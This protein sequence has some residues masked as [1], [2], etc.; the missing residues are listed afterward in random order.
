MLKFNSGEISRQE[1]L[2]RVRLIK[3]N[4]DFY[5]DNP[6]VQDPKLEEYANVYE[7]LID[8]H[9]ITPEEIEEPSES[10]SIATTDNGTSQAMDPVSVYYNNNP[11]AKDEE[12]FIKANKMDRNYDLALPYKPLYRAST[13]EFDASKIFQ[14]RREEF[15]PEKHKDWDTS[16]MGQLADAY[17]LGI[18]PDHYKKAIKAGVPHDYLMDTFQKSARPHTIQL[19]DARALGT[20]RGVHFADTNAG[21][22]AREYAQ[23]NPGPTSNATG[24]ANEN[25]V[26]IRMSV[27]HPLDIASG[28]TA[29]AT[30]DEL[31]DAWKNNGFHPLAQ[32]GSE[33]TEPISKYISARDMGINHNEAKALISSPTYI[34]EVDFKMD[35]Q[36]GNSPAAIINI[37]NG[38]KPDSI[39]GPGKIAIEN[40]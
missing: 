12:E 24:I 9:G 22:A 5:Y 23:D 32:Y 13:D 14:Q 38:Y 35:L 33:F 34:P 28:Y 40:E 15:D 36:K 10:E 25:W 16:L 3:P 37:R 39:E 30:S 8:Q 7:Q 26:P 4:V 29:G 6:T 21:L 19:P 27:M 1:A 20:V 2:D 11:E 17:E 18:D 31:L